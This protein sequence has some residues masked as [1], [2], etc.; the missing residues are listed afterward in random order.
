LATTIDVGSADRE[1]AR[2]G[3]CISSGSGA[4]ALGEEGSGHPQRGGRGA[5]TCFIAQTVT[6]GAG[7]SAE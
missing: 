6:D 7:M 2:S 1:T 5:R 4:V 3:I